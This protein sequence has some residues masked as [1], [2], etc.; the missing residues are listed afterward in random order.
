MCVCVCACWP[1]ARCIR[2]I[3]CIAITALPSPQQEL[4]L[5]LLL[6]LLQTMSRPTLLAASPFGRSS[7]L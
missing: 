6:L 2:A 4:L 5:L 7:M 3:P 1:F